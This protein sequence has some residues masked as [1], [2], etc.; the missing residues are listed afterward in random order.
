MGMDS[1]MSVFLEKIRELMSY[2]GDREM[3]RKKK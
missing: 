2:A 1:T 3:H